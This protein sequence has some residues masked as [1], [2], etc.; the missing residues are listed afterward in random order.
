MKNN[1]DTVAMV[2][3]GVNDVLALKRADC[4]IAM[5][6][7][8]EAA[9]NVSHVV[10]VNSDFASLPD[11][12][13]EGR[14]V[15][16]NLQRTSSLFLVKTIFSMT[17]T[18]VF[19]ITLITINYAYPF[20]AVHF[21]LWS[22][23]GIGISAFFLALERNKEPL[24]GSFIGS[25]FMKAVPGAIA[26]LLPVGLIYLTYALQQN[27]ALFTGIYDIEVAAFMSVLA[28][29]FISLIIL[30]KIC[31]PFS[32][33]RA[34]VFAGAATVEIGLVALAAT[35]SYHNHI[36]ESIIA[37]NFQELTLVN[38]FVLGIIVI[39][40]SALYLIVTY[41]IEVFKGEHLNDKN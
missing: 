11:I 19:L 31:L 35:L 16:N 9:K 25:I 27:G 17:T 1:G 15:I 37:I 7:G 23:V 28:F 5:N 30:L 34:F 8:S 10:L 4:S 39:L 13:N 38:W 18:L 41:I 29:N 33:Y 20:E 22:F 36:T 3:D 2:G 14:R 40:V 32:K 12:V 21:Q 6:S 26:T 24:K